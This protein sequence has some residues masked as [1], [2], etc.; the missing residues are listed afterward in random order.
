MLW[1]V[2]AGVPDE[3]DGADQGCGVHGGVERGVSADVRGAA[4]GLLLGA[5]GGGALHHAGRRQEHPPGR[6]GVCAQ[7]G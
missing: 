7:G 5:H 1:G 2:V 6:G 3:G 4:G